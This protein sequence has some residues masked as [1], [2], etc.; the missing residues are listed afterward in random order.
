MSANTRTPL[1]EPARDVVQEKFDALNNRCD[2][3]RNQAQH[4]NALVD[5]VDSNAVAR[6]R[7]N[8]ERLSALGQQLAAA[9]AHITGLEAR[10]RALEAAVDG[11]H[12]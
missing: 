9:I 8:D 7:D 12:K 5:T 6:D 4:I 11:D 2:L 3:L 10:V 1:I